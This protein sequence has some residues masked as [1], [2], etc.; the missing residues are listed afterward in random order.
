MSVPAKQGSNPGSSPSPLSGRRRRPRRWT[1]SWDSTVSRRSAESCSSSWPPVAVPRP[2]PCLG[3]LPRP[4]VSLCTEETSTERPPSSSPLGW[5]LGS[6]SN[7]QPR[8]KQGVAET[9]GFLP[10]WVKTKGGPSCSMSRRGNF[11]WKMINPFPTSLSL[12]VGVGVGVGVELIS[13][14]IEKKNDM[15]LPT[16]GQPLGPRPD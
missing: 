9:H 1:W 10:A 2:P 7:R 11:R 6:R 4:S 8:R 14:P 16:Q 13:G 5:E 12:V 3:Q 15:W